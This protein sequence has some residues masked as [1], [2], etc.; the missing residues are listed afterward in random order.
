L[1][2]IG[3]SFIRT[4]GDGAQQRSAKKT[5]A[6]YAADILVSPNLMTWNAAV[7]DTLVVRDVVM[8]EL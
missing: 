4:H 7:Y 1:L 2:N 8:A 3:T 5:P 6:R